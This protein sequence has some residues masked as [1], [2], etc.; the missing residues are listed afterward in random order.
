MLCIL[1]LFFLLLFL[2]RRRLA[3]PPA[4]DLDLSAAVSHKGDERFR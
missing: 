2:L 4:I 3:L 1:F